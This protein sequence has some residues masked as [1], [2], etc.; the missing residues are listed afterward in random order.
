[1]PRGIKFTYEEVKQYF[2]DHDC[3]LLETEYKNSKTL[4][5]YRCDCGNPDICKIIFSSF[6][7]GSRCIICGGREKHTF[8][9]VYNYFKERKCKLL[10]TE[11]LNARTKM[12]YECDCGNSD[13]KIRFDSFKSG[14]RC[15]DCSGNKIKKKL[16]HSYEHVYNYFKKYDCK[17]LDK[18]YTN[19]HKKI[20]FRCPC[21]R[22]DYI[23]FNKFQTK[24]YKCCS[25]CT[26]KKKNRGKNH[27]NWIEDREELK[28]INIFRRRCRTIL[29]SVLKRIGKP[30][31]GKTYDIL[32]YN[33]EELREHVYSHP[34]WEKIKDE[35][36]HID[37]IFPIQ[38]FVEYNIRDIKLI[39][40][41]ENLQPL[42]EEDNLKKGAKYDEKEFESWLI[43][44]G[45]ENIRKQ[46][47]CSV[48]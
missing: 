29:R 16:S 42:T 45:Y 34:N 15:I 23:T 19:V 3:E 17:M 41:F 7:N 43:G 1:M 14:G 44:K 26:K 33:S 12:R 11:Y 27:W 48:S 13:C 28:E 5:R 25:E 30:K 4:M 6:K 36:W 37:H 8:E 32:G 39:N 2:E 35:D 31:N 20:R 40:C 21:T 46:G 9:F 38:A 18:V 47:F 22:V 24:K 10:E